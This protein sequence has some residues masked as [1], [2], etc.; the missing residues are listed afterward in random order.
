MR[1]L[2]PPPLTSTPSTA[3]MAIHTRGCLRKRRSS[4]ESNSAGTP[5]VPGCLMTKGL[6]KPFARSTHTRAGT[7]CLSRAP[8]ATDPYCRK[9]GVYSG[10]GRERGGGVKSRRREDVSPGQ[11]VRPRQYDEGVAPGATRNA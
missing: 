6:R 2:P 10:G 1:K 5:R 9:G 7:L 8:A 3:R 11:Q 4:K